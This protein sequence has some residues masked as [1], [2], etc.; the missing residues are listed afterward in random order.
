M[1]SNHNNIALLL[2]THLNDQVGEIRTRCF[3]IL[4]E[5]APII[6][7]DYVQENAKGKVFEYFK[8]E[9]VL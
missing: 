6:G 2:V 8:I 7:I 5:F 9:E 3:K 4:K 1:D